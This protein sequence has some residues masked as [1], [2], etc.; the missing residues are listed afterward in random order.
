MRSSHRY[1]GHVMLT[2][3]C[4][5]MIADTTTDIDSSR[6]ALLEEARRVARSGAESPT[7]SNSGK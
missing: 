2:E 6:E 4:A 3:H 5:D 7:S 1:S